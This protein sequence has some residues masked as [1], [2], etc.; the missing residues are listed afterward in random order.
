MREQPIFVTVDSVIFYAHE[1]ELYVVLIK[2]KNDPFKLKWALPGGFLEEEETLED[3]A[4]RELK[5]E[6]GIE[7]TSL[8]QVG[9]FANPKRDP[10]GRIISIAFT[11][12]LST[13]VEVTA[14][15][16]AGAAAWHNVTDLPILAFDHFEIINAA[17]K[18]IK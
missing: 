4:A 14:G 18:Y 9:I 10:R 8:K 13:K 16:D 7:I 2:R 15:D 11:G 5:E 17:I 12:K 1:S 6:T 3:G